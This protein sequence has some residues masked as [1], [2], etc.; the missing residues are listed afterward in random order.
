VVGQAV[1]PAKASEARPART[2]FVASK[3][4]ITG[5]CAASARPPPRIDLLFRD[6]LDASGQFIQ[7]ALV[8]PERAQVLLAGGRFLD[9]DG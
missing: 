7:A 1:S 6:L 9:D 5:P 4:T 2:R 8:L 3:V